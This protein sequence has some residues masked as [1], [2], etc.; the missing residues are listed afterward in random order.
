MT[1]GSRH[2][3]DPVETPRFFNPYGEIRFTKNLLP[4][5]QQNGATYFITFRLADSVP[6]HLRTQWEEERATWLRFHP[7]PW[8][9]RTEL[10]YHKR[11]TG[12]I[13]RL[14]AG[15]GSCV[16][17]RIECAKIVDEA[18]RHFDRQRLVL[19]S[20]VVMP[21]HVHALLI[22]NPDIRWN[23]YF[24]AGNRSVHGT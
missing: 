6:T 18:L 13:E 15:Y 11:F 10:E 7:E 9:V 17:R 12:A 20:S 22:R 14:D 8:D 5:W 23:I 19:I 2:S 3:L 21:S 16:L 4:H 24:T 1:A